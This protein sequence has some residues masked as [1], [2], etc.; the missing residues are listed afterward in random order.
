MLL[1]RCN[2]PSAC[3]EPA[4]CSCSAGQTCVQIVASCNTCPRNDCVGNDSAESTGATVS[5]SGASKGALAGGIIGALIFFAAA[6]ALFLYYRRRN[7]LRSTNPEPE[8]KDV[9][10]PAAMVLNR[11]DPTEK[12]SSI[13][14]HNS[15]RVYSTSSTTTIDLDPE[16]QQNS[17]HAYMSSRGSTA[18][19]PFDDGNSIQTAGTEGTN[20]IPIALVSPEAQ[21][22]TSS[23][24]TRP[25]RSPE[26]T[27]N[28]N[29]EHVNVSKDSMRPPA[30][31]A[32]SQI[33]GVSSRNS[34]MSGASYSSDFLNEA[35]M[36]VTASKGQVRQ[37]GVAKPEVITA[38]GLKPS[39]AFMR[40]PSVRSPLAEASFGPADIA[41]DS[42][43]GH[44]VVNPFSDRHVSTMTNRASPS[45]SVTTFGQPSPPPPRRNSGNSEWETPNNVQWVQ[46]DSVT[47]PSSMF[48]QAGSVIGIENATR[49]NVGMG[50][51]TPQTAQF[52]PSAYRTTMGRLVSPSTALATA[53]SMQEQQQAALARQLTARPV[54]GSSAISGTAD[55]ILESFPFV[56]PSPISN[57]P[58]RTPPISPLVQE[59]FTT[60][61]APPSPLNQS[62]LPQK[63]KHGGDDSD[64]DL[65]SPPN[66]RTLGL[67]TGSQ[68]STASSGLGSFPFQIDSGNEPEQLTPTSYNGRQRASLDTLAITGEISQY[69]LGFDRDSTLPPKN[70]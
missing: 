15:V 63:S 18:S 41:K 2:G 21:S 19:N 27:L 47:R 13:I 30:G 39:T 51:G 49:V 26:L 53:G 16:S 12:P 4:P 56:P 3:G 70:N 1:E 44:S 57:R 36:I 59:T 5:G 65:P 35:P 9:P 62:F 25:L 37:L 48:T 43:D 55:S 42:D 60:T 52:S 38:E 45:A 50:Y 32:I 69:P 29:L 22:Q 34:Y 40:K 61:V 33:S 7:R 67:S 31:Y 54:S 8:I 24:P 14:E 66:R 46:D 23:G 28:Y 58:M 6:V 20:V 17:P 64:S 11:P 10:A 68:F